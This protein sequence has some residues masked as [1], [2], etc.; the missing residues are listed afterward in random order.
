MLANGF[1]SAQEVRVDLQPQ[2]SSWAS[3]PQFCRL[4]V[5]KHLSWPRWHLLLSSANLPLLGTCRGPNFTQEPDQKPTF[6]PC[7]LFAPISNL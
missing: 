5:Q 4:W 3:E 6:Y 1:D 7:F 2:H